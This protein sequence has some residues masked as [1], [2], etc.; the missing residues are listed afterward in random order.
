[1]PKL[2]HLAVSGFREGPESLV[3]G[4]RED[5]PAQGLQKTLAWFRGETEA[6]R[7]TVTHLSLASKGPP[8][9]A[10]PVPSLKPGDSHRPRFRRAG[11]SPAAP[12]GRGDA[13]GPAWTVSVGDGFQGEISSSL[14]SLSF[15][16]AHKMSPPLCSACGVLLSRCI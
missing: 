1:M 7:G 13:T 3:A 6:G 5:S 12:A 4:L 11:L 8:A 14:E 9:D 2:E 10:V 16:A 15:K